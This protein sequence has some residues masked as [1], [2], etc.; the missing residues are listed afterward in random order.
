MSGLLIYSCTRGRCSYNINKQLIICKQN[1]RLRALRM[2]VKVKV[3]DEKGKEA[4]PR[5][6]SYL[7]IS[8]IIIIIAVSSP[9]PMRDYIM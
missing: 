6:A 8:V 7:Q 9:H 3:K 4:V 2:K 5:C 1:G